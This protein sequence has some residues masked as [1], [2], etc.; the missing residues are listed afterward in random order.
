MIWANGIQIPMH[1]CA[2][3]V[4]MA[5]PAR[6]FDGDRCEQ[7]LDTG[8]FLQLSNVRMELKWI[9][10]LCQTTFE[11]C[12]FGA[13]CLGYPNTRLAGKY[14]NLASG[15][16]LNEESEDLALSDYGER[17]NFEWGHSHMCYEYG[18]PDRV[19]WFVSK[20]CQGQATGPFAAVFVSRQLQ[21]V[22][23]CGWRCGVVV[24]F[25]TVIM[26]S[27]NA[28]GTKSQLSEG[29]KKVIINHLQICSLAA[30]FPLKWPAAIE[31]IFAIMSAVSSPAQYLLSPD[32]ELSWM[33]GAEVFYNKQIGYAVMPAGVTTICA[34]LWFVGPF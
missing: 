19:R 10:P 6:V 26:V 31:A 32:C 13:A 12:L 23:F 28:G 18:N 1:G 22:S 33:S 15:D 21:T 24:G 3:S 7:S 5:A 8:E 30:L 11:E 9:T 27:I 14:Y 16:S 2:K 34:S 17:C 29:V 4:H 25:T 20:L